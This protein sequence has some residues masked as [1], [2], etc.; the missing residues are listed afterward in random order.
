[1]AGSVRKDGDSATGSRVD[2]EAEMRQT[3]L[4]TAGRAE[5]QLTEEEK[6]VLIECRRNSTARGRWAWPIETVNL[7]LVLLQVWRQLQAQFF[8]YELSLPQ[9][10]LSLLSLSLTLTLSVC[11][12]S[13]TP[14]PAMV[15]NL[16]HFCWSSEFPDR[17]EVLQTDLSEQDHV[18]GPL[19]AG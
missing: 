5:L 7:D 10:S 2:Q 16:L 13:T 1:M 15:F 6:A 18:S 8:S 9:V 14:P 17:I 4:D 11:R 19:C 3:Q 12:P